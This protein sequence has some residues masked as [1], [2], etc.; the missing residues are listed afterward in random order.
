M[1]RAPIDLSVFVARME[2]L[3]QYLESNPLLDLTRLR[4]DKNNSVL[5]ITA[6]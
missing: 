5:H 2:V 6:Y 1:E 3:C 4:D